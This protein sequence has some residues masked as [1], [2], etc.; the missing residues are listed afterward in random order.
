MRPSRSAGGERRCH[1]GRIPQNPR[2]YTR[3]FRRV[4]GC[5]AVAWLTAAGLPGE[6]QIE[7]LAHSGTLTWT[8][9][10]TNGSYRIEWAPTV[11]GPWLASWS[12]LTNVPATGAPVSVAV[13]MFYRV[14]YVPPPPLLAT[15]NAAAAFSLI[16]NRAGDTNFVV[17][18]VRTPSEHA[19]RHVRGALNL[20]FY[21][22]DF[23]TRIEALDRR[24]SYL[25]YCASGSRS[26]QATAR[27]HTLGF[28]VV[29]NL[30]GGFGTLAALPG[31]AGWLEP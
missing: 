20:D 5:V 9:P 15:V 16:T 25:V 31:S 22:A 27:M 4:L 14:V 30:G 29:Y 17:L 6:V 18:D 12:T 7:A 1:G 3:W 23:T 11:Q 26:G 13:P 24:K 10:A 19:V 21:S 8:G 2:M 28:A